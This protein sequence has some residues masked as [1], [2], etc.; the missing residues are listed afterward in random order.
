MGVAVAPGEALNTPGRWAF[1]CA[2]DLVLPAADPTNPRIDL[3][4]LADDGTL[5]GPT[6]NAALQGTPAAEPSAPEVPEGYLALA[7]ILVDAE[8]TSIAAEKI[9]DRRYVLTTVRDHHDA[10][11]LHFSGTE[12]ADCLLS[13]EQKTD[14]TGAGATVLH[15]HTG[16]S[17][18]EINGGSES[19]KPVT[20]DGLAGTKSMVLIVV[21]KGTD[22]AV[23]DDQIQFPVPQALNGM[24]L[25]SAN[26]IVNTAGET[27]A[28]TVSVRNV[29][30]SQEMLSS[31]IS[32]ASGDRVGTPGTINEGYDDVATNDIL[33]IDVKTVSTTA[34]KG[35]M[36]ML[37]FRL[38]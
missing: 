8:V 15:Y 12:K 32:I 29:T 20:P 24:N 6:Q 14:L 28:T 37:E 11:T 13:A 5:E 22:V 9:T 34:P 35:L 10:T 25:V 23:G 18:G 2:T 27:N 1:E 38:P 3:V 19:V 33:R 26:A 30:D 7:E 36:V 4:C 21:E 17:A 16:A 31:S